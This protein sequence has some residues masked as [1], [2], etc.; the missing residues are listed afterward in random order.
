MTVSGEISPSTLM[1]L[2]SRL[3]EQEVTP[4]S[5][6]TAFSTRAWQAAQLIP[7]T[8]YCSMIMPFCYFISFIRIFTSSSTEPSSPARMSFA[9]QPLIWQES[10]SLL[11]LFR[12]L[13]TAD[14]WMRISGQ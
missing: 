6:L 7:V 13:V 3:T 14:T 9:T 5:E 8:I 10:S 11:K 1:E 2:V 4:G 12:A